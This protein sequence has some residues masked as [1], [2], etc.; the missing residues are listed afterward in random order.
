MPNST[1]T[2]Q[3]FLPPLP[4]GYVL[5]GMLPEGYVILPAPRPPRRQAGSCA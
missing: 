3:V 1:P 5:G 4:A 2:R